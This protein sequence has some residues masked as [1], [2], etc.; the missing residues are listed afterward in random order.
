MSELLDPLYIL[1][2]LIN[3]V[4]M[5][6]ILKKFLY[7]PVK[8]FMADRQQ[9]YEDQKKDA[10]H[11]CAQAQ[12]RI[13]EADQA[14]AEAKQEAK[15][16]IRKASDDASEQKKAIVDHA[17]QQAQAQLAA[18]DAAIARNQ[19]HVQEEIRSA[20][21]EIGVALAKSI[22]QREIQSGDHQR[23]VDEYLEKVTDHAQE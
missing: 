4:V 3:L 15:Q 8:K 7:K 1:F 20:S 17:Q 11:L 13:A 10:E 6:L 23:I 19:A 22:L 14:V 9:H 21:V 18:A 2:H 12:Q 16:I 5:F